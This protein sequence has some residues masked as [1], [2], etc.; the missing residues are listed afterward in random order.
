MKRLFFLAVLAIALA[1]CAGNQYSGVEAQAAANNLAVQNRIVEAVDELSEEIDP[2]EMLLVFSGA[3]QDTSGI[4]ST[5]TLLLIELQKLSRIGRTHAYSECTE[6]QVSPERIEHGV[7]LVSAKRFDEIL[8]TEGQAKAV[9][10][11]N[12]ADKL[13]ILL[14]G[15]SF[16]FVALAGIFKLIRW[17][18]SRWKPPADEILSKFIPAYQN[19]RELGF[20]KLAQWLHQQATDGGLASMTPDQ[21][22]TM[23][24]DFI[25]DDLRNRLPG[26]IQKAIKARK[27]K[28]GIS[29]EV[30]GS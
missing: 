28:A 5:P 29:L 23:T 4:L 7:G 21:I 11:K 8:E 16:S 6:K 30:A 13:S 14:F 3:V 9:A 17:A 22:K 20:A 2:E 18:I 25:D 24:R 27:D 10:G 1:K 26:K 12:W 19:V 15:A